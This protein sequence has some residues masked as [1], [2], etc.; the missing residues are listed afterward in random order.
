[1]DIG[2]DG[3]SDG[4]DEDEFGSDGSSEGGI[5]G[6]SESG[7]DGG[8]VNAACF[9]PFTLVRTTSTNVS[10]AWASLHE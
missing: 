4:K 8:G 2:V 7:S 9:P 10:W 6:K 1:M 3:G 5:D